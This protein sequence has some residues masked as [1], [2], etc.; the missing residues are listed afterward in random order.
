M[1]WKLDEFLTAMR[2]GIDPDGHTLGEQVP[3]RVIGRMS[4]DG[5]RGLCEYLVDLPKA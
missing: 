3:W 2:T 1:K 4:G 5:L